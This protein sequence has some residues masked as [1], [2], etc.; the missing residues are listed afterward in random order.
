MKLIPLLK[1]RNMKQAVSFYTE[2]LDFTLKFPDEELNIFCVDLINGDAELQLTETDGIFGVAINVWVDEVDE[3]FKKYMNRGL[4]N[5]K[6]K[7][8]PV[9]QSPLDQTWGRR[10]FY[11]TDNDGNTLRFTALI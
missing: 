1:V 10:E 3:L 2:I 7:E 4:D 5:S 8:S 9:H 6:K 11:V